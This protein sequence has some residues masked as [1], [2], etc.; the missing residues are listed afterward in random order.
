MRLAGHLCSTRCEEVLNGD[1]TY[2]A[3][4]HNEVNPN[5]AQSFAMMRGLVLL[6]IFLFVS[7]TF[8]QLAHP[9][10]IHEELATNI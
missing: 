2:I 5:T 4:L 7:P 1:A 8:L 9:R 10:A 3:M 6:D